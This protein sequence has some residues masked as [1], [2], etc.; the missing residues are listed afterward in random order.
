MSHF[1]RH[2]Q[3]AASATLFR[4]SYGTGNYR[5][6]TLNSFKSELICTPSNTYSH[7][8]LLLTVPPFSS[9]VYEHGTKI[10]F[11]ELYLAI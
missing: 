8:K 11:M 1:D 6:P 2:G 9:T 7:T 10:T 4:L 3:D 5:V